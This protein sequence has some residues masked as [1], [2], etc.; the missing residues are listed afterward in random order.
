MFERLTDLSFQRTP[1]QAF[2]FYL[3]WLIGGTFLTAIIVFLYLA[4]KGEAPLPK[5]KGFADGM[6]IGQQ[7]AMNVVPFVVF[8][9]STAF[10]A[11]VARAKNTYNGVTLLCIFLAAVLSIIGAI[12]SFIPAAY[13]TTLPKKNPP[14]QGG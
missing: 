14:Q 8:L 6:Q 5:G 10:S 13:L 7:V 2:G 9:I 3:A 1:K 12:F 11:L 4:L